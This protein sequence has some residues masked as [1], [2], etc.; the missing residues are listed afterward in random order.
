MQ[1]L[2]L[3]NNDKRILWMFRCSRRIEKLKITIKIF[4]SKVFICYCLTFF[5]IVFLCTDNIFV[6]FIELYYLLSVQIGVTRALKWV[7]KTCGVFHSIWPAFGGST[8]GV[9][10]ISIF[11]FDFV[12]FLIRYKK[13]LP[14]IQFYA[15]FL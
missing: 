12:Q 11:V 9:C 4:Y 2:K 8:I 13:R 1:K 14:K 10:F 15:G 6:L 7:Y 5:P 3:M